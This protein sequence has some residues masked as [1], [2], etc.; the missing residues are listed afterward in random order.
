LLAQQQLESR[1]KFKERELEDL[2]H[3][4]ANRIAFAA[5]DLYILFGWLPVYLPFYFF[6]RIANAEVPDDSDRLVTSN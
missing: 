4:S 6:R 2:L 3:L 1:T 5:E